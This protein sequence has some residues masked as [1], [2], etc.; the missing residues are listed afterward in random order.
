M[1]A[2]P[3]DEPAQLSVT[4]IGPLEVRRDAMVLHA[5]DLGGPKPR[6]ILE[7]LLL[8]RGVP[9]S[10][11]VLIDLLWGDKVPREARAALE[12]YVSV[13]RRHLQPALGRSGPLRTTT[14]GYLIDE[15]V[16]DLDLARFDALLHRAQRAEAAI[17]HPLVVQALSL[18]NGPLLGDE[19]RPAWADEARRRHADAVSAAR[20]LAAESAAALGANDEAILWANQALL[21][22]PLH[23]GAWMALILALERSRQYAEG[24]RA[25][26]RCRLVLDRE[27]GC[28]PS[29]AL[30]AAHTR[31]LQATAT[32]HGELSHAVSA[33]LVLH[34]QLVRGA[35]AGF[36]EDLAEART[37]DAVRHAG[38]VL[39]SFLR[40]AIQ[41]A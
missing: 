10:K 6:Q 22:D 34:D 26:G 1:H 12:S 11:D 40:R 28:E 32:G 8:R 39:A 13:L 41:V 29:P 14:G 4:I 35:Q 30:R 33:L 27:L 20:V 23:E 16:V 25:Y 24:L 7:I 3:V 15:S 2:Q 38:D 18:A 17:A 37:D 36:E 31:L 19:L 5:H 9:V 21:D